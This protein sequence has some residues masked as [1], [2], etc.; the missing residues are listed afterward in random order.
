[1]KNLDIDIQH[2][3]HA[4]HRQTDGPLQWT[5]ADDWDESVLS[6]VLRCPPVW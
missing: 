2:F 5:S 3:F 6:D 1:M 4:Y